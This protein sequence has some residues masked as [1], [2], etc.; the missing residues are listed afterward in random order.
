VPSDA[1]HDGI[2]ETLRNR[3]AQ[4]RQAREKCQRWY[5]QH[6]KNDSCFG[7]EAGDASSPVRLHRFRT[8]VPCRATPTARAL[9][10]RLRRQFPGSTI[11]FQRLRGGSQAV[12]LTAGDGTEPRQIGRIEQSVNADYARCAIR[13]QGL[14]VDTEGG[15][16]VLTFHYP[17]TAVRMASPQLDRTARVSFTELRP[18]LDIRPSE[19]M[20]SPRVV[21]MT[22]P[23]AETIEALQNRDYEAFYVRFKLEVLAAIWSALSGL[24]SGAGGAQLHRGA[25]YTLVREADADIGRIHQRTVDDSGRVVDIGQNLTYDAFAAT[26][27]LLLYLDGDLLADMAEIYFTLERVTTTEARP[28]REE[29]FSIVRRFWTASQSLTSRY[30][31]VHLAP[32]VRMSQRAVPMPTQER[33]LKQDWTQLRQLLI[34]RYGRGGRNANALAT[35]DLHRPRGGA[36]VWPFST[37]PAGDVNVGLRLVYRQEWTH[38]GNRNLDQ[39][40]DRVAT[41]TVELTQWSVDCDGGINVGARSLATT[42]DAGLEWESRESSRDTSVRLNDIAGRI[43][44]GTRESATD[45]AAGD[46]ERDAD[47]VQTPVVDKGAEPGDAPAHRQPYHF[48]VL[49]RLCAVENVV[50]VA[51]RLPSPAD[52]GLAWVRQHSW[53]LE[54]ALLD[55]SFRDALET[56]RLVARAP[57]SIGTDSDTDATRSLSTLREQLYDHL[58]ANILHYQRAIWRQEDGQQRSARYRKAS[59]RV[60]LD[61]RFEL[62]A[63]GALTIDELAERLARNSVDGQFAAYSDGHDADLEQLIDP[64][65]P[66]GYYGNYTVYRMRP[67]FGTGDLFAMLHFFKSPYLRANAQTG[68][69]EVADPEEI[70][71]TDDPGALGAFQRARTRRVTVYADGAIADEWPDES[72]A[73]AG[74]EGSHAGIVRCRSPDEVQLTLESGRTTILTHMGCSETGAQW[75]LRHAAAQRASDLVAGPGGVVRRT[76]DTNPRVV[77]RTRKRRPVLVVG[78]GGDVHQTN[79]PPS[80]PAIRARYPATLT[81]RLRVGGTP[82]VAAQVIARTGGKDT[83]KLLAGVGVARNEERLIVARQQSRLR[84]S[85]V[86]R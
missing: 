61:W 40:V 42:T 82:A 52:I 13:H 62:E 3:G 65:S 15:R 35:R 81:Q 55:E 9:L 70:G 53:I 39:L 36:P 76:L 45:S 50:L 34:D 44:R 71:I 69:A 11:T 79:T 33:L 75:W 60:P 46:A 14:A 56:I 5:R 51:E 85:P 25:H 16:L 19:R 77:V 67:E 27:I 12:M 59:R 48:D 80:T 22:S 28:L 21:W 6:I 54:N 84:P 49:T 23:E 78:G 38:L 10:D 29:F 68:A 31:G 58:R 26:D 4:D 30:Y 86:A 47:T 41:A 43:A 32:I 2:I 18:A 66:I 8:K 20:P 37:A 83:E 73:T 64:A 1:T 17:Q 74:S 7:H 72:D 63:G 24:L 57:T